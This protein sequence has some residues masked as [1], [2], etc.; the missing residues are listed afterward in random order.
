M[1]MGRSDFLILRM[2][3]VDGMSSGGGCLTSSLEETNIVSSNRGLQV[4]DTKV[5]IVNERF[6]ELG[7]SKCKIPCLESWYDLS[8]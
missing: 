1:T 5:R 8:R 7:G 2:E 6:T 4:W 3:G